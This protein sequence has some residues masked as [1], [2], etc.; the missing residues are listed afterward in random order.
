MKMFHTFQKF[1]ISLTCTSHEIVLRRFGFLLRFASASVM[2]A[3]A[4]VLCSLTMWWF[5]IIGRGLHVDTLPTW[6]KVFVTSS[7]SKTSRLSVTS[8][9]ADSMSV[10]LYVAKSSAFVLAVSKPS[11]TSLSVIASRHDVEAGTVS[12][13]NTRFYCS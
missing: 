2:L 12:C 1:G 5:T 7:L 8:W 9:H 3:V 6:H 11:V 4:V 13:G 10:P